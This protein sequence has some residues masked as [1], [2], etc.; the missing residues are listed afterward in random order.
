MEAADLNL[1]GRADL[2][3]SPVSSGNSISVFLNNGDGTFASA[4]SYPVGS[5]PGLAAVRDVNGDGKLDI[6]ALSQ[7][8]GRLYLLIGKGD[9]TFNAA[10]VIL[11]P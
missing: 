5:D 3:A 2:I 9:G 8:V 1:D 4:V 7:S 6:L 11:L 10:T